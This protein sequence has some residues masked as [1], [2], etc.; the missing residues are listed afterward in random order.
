M[1]DKLRLKVSKDEVTIEEGENTF[2]GKLMEGCKKHITISTPF[3]KRE[4]HK[5]KDS[6]GKVFKDD[7]QEGKKTPE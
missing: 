4:I 5:V 6:K 2:L 3:G 1:R 7:K